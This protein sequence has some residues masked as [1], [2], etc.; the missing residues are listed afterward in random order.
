MWN[1]LFCFFRISLVHIFMGFVSWPFTSVFFKK[2]SDKGYTISHI[3]GWLVIGYT[4]FCLSSFRILRFSNLGLGLLILLWIIFNSLLQI[5]LKLI[6]RGNINIRRIL[7]VQILFLLLSAFMFWLLRHNYDVRWAERFMNLAFLKSLDNVDYLPLFDVW[8][9]GKNLNYYYFGHYIAYLILQTAQVNIIQGFPLVAVWIFG[10]FGIL[11]FQLSIEIGRQFKSLKKNKRLLFCSGLL[12]IFFV[13]FA[14]TFYEL[15]WGI[16]YLLLDSLRLDTLVHRYT[17]VDSTFYTIPNTVTSFSFDLFWRDN[18]HAY[19][20]GLLTSIVLIFTY[21]L[22]WIKKDSTKFNW[23]LYLLI[24]FLLS[25]LFIT[26]SWDVFPLTVLGGTILIFRYFKKIKQNYIYI[27][28]ALVLT[29]LLFYIFTLPWSLNVNIPISGLG[30]VRDRS[31][32]FMWVSLWGP[33]IV[34]FSVSL[35]SFFDNKRRLL[36]RKKILLFILIFAINISFFW[37]F[38]ELFYLI[39]Y[40]VGNRYYRQNTVFK[41]YYHLWTWLGLLLGPLLI[42]TLVKLRKSF[43]IKKF[44]L[45]LFILITILLQSIRP[46][47][48]IRTIV[49]GNKQVKFSENLSFWQKQYPYDFQAYQFL[50]KY[51]LDSN[52]ERFNIVEAAGYSYGEFNYFSSILGWPTILGYPLHEYSWRWQ[53][54]YTD[55]SFENHEVGRRKKEVKYIYTGENIEKTKEILKKYDIDLI[56]LGQIEKDYYKEQV[57]EEK[58]ISLGETIF[59]NKKTRIIKLHI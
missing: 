42:L 57:Q 8:Y 38:V 45:L 24:V 56:I 28:I 5:K 49:E 11:V 40:N 27:L 52:K 6:K 17:F 21:L 44:F 39:D 33:F 51:K 18:L 58:L 34:L 31:P 54:N 26:N 13:M 16:G 20:W 2:L 43:D 47:I 7:K 3:F 22:V 9:L 1:D 36:I 23:K 32:F 35:I 19:I 55:I 14:G 25:I 10:I 15:F 29:P 46:I 30:I 53:K 12:S 37:V 48:T 50:N 41:T 59:E 4:Y